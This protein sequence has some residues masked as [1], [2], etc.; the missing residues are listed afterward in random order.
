MSLY[1]QL[2][3]HLVRRLL[4]GKTVPSGLVELHQYFR[5][6][7]PITFRHEKQEDGSIVVV[8]ENFRYGSIISRAEK[9]EELNDKIIDA[10]LTAFE[11][12][13]SY[14]KEANLHR[15]GQQEYAFA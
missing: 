5:M 1:K 2:K 6:Y 11:V 9:E 15:I 13:S 14:A 12:P 7:D 3:D 4:N 8:S 10:I